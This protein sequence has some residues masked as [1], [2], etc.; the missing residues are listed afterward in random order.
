MLESMELSLDR[1]KLP[2]LLGR[3]VTEQLPQG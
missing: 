3:Q 1:E 2:L